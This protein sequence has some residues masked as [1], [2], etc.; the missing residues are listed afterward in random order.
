MHIPTILSS[1]GFFASISFAT[2]TLEDDYGNTNSFFDKFDFWSQ[3]D[4]SSGFVKYLDQRSARSTG[5]ISANGGSVYI[6]V[7]N[8]STTTTGRPSVRITSKKRYTK[9]LFIL[10]LAHM[11]ASTC[12]SWPAL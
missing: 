12:G 8:S 7:D 4:P 6:G 1:L 2:Y 9:G 5:L 3:P 11:P 10:D